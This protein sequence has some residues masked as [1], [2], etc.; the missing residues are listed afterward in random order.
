MEQKA[1]SEERKPDYKLLYFVYDAN[2]VT[3]W[4]QSL[5]PGSRYRGLLL[6][7]NRDNICAKA[8]TTRVWMKNPTVA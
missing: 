2:I 7:M 4:N 1:K 5:V 3:L 6:L 8:E